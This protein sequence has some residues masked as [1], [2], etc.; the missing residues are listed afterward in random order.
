MTFDWL[1]APIGRHNNFGLI[2]IFAAYQ[3]LLFHASYHLKF[4]L[5][6]VIDRFA[7]LLPGVPAFFFISGLLV[8]ASLATRGDLWQYAK[9]RVRRIVPGLWLAVVASIILL[10]VFGRLDHDVLSNW[11]FPAWL[12]SQF[13][14]VE[15]F[16]PSFFR[17]FGVGVVNGSLWTIP[18][19]MGF[20]VILPVLCVIASHASLPRQAL[21]RLFVAGGIVSFA[22][23]IAPIDRDDMLIKILD[24]TPVEHFH[25]FA[26]GGLAYLHYSRLKAI[27]IGRFW[28]LFAA[29]I[30]MAF[31]LSGLSEQWSGPTIQ[32]LLVIPVFAFAVGTKPLSAPWGWD[33]SYG[34]YLFHMLIVNALVELDVL[35]AVGFSAATVA[36]TLVALASWAFWEKPWLRGERKKIARSAQIQIR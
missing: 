2:R 31:M 13:F 21:S 33:I 27:V 22:F 17:S 10:A 25:L 35:G 36:V 24:A 20:Y 11:R 6:W 7:G 3:V 19:E 30:A 5:P 32:V 8:T 16:H 28:P 1:S 12:A 34:T 15:V 23:A 18:V 29:F 4:Q 9:Q 14:F 26:L